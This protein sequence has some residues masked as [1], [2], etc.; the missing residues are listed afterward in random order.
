MRINTE[1]RKLEIERND[2]EE[3]EEKCEIEFRA[4]MAG[5]AFK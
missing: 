1:L 4:H 5:F 2:E 3:D